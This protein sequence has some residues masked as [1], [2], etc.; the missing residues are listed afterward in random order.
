MTKRGTGITTAQ[1]E[2]APHGAVF[3]WLT[4]DTFYPKKLAERIGRT[5]L[6][7]VSPI[8]LYHGWI[9]REISGLVIDHAAKKNLNLRQLENI[10]HARVRIRNTNGI[11]RHE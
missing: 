9:G 1:M 6:E 10:E 4:S 11:G 2:S 7:I 5:D 8:W 3:I